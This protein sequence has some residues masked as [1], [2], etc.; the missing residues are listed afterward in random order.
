MGLFRQPANAN[1]SGLFRRVSSFSLWG[2]LCSLFAFFLGTGNLAIAVL[3]LAAIV[4]LVIILLGPQ[5]IAAFLFMG[6]PTFFA[7]PNEILRPLPFVTMERILMFLLVVMLFLKS[8][9]IKTRLASLNILESLIVVFLCYAFASLLVNT[10]AEKAS[11]DGWFLIQYALPMTAFMVSRRIEWSEKGLKILLACLIM[12]GMFLAVTGILQAVFGITLFKI[13]YQTVTAGHIGRAYGTFSNAHTY[14]AT[15]FI[16]L[17]LTLLQFN[18]YRDALLRSL[19]LFAMFVMLI[20]IV[21]GETRAPWGGAACA[22][23][24]IFLRDRAVRPLLVVGGVIALMGGAAVLY[25]MMDQ[26]DSFFNRVTSVS[27][28]AGRLAVWAT[29]LNMIAHNP[30]FGVG[31]GADSFLLNKPEYITGIG[32]LTAQYAVYLSVPHNEF[33]HVTVLLGIP[34][35]VLFLAIFY[36]LLK[37][38]FRIHVES[39]TPTLR[40]RL[41]L[42]AGAIVVGLL[43]NSLFS[44]TFVQDYFWMLAFFLAGLVAGMPRDFGRSQPGPAPG[45]VPS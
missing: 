14:I 31:F 29:A 16:F 36:Q 18:M 45:G 6:S 21:L 19:L 2:G 15:L 38:L 37:L 13:E 10:T 11:K 39:E 5:F 27:T 24:I 8:A 4:F 12:V 26:L 44:D 42:Y 20:G 35:L 33:L 32:P 7:F 1:P 40:S 17:A 34:G 22:L 3:L 25:V 23:L 43:F 28:F 41:G 9:L 30:V